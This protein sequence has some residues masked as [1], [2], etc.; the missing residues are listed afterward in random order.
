MDSKAQLTVGA[1]GLFVAAWSESRPS[2]KVNRRGNQSLLLCVMSLK[3]QY[4]KYTAL[5]ADPIGW[6][7]SC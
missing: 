5:R 2:L 6:A 4:N 7:N 1:A 3:P